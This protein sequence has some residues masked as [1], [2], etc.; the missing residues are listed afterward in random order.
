MATAH[1]QQVGRWY[2]FA[3]LASMCGG[4]L[5]SYVPRSAPVT[6]PDRGG[7]SSRHAR[8]AW[9]C[10]PLP[11]HSATHGNGL[12]LW[13]RTRGLVLVV[14]TMERC[15]QGREAGQIVLAAFAPGAARR[16]SSG[17]LPMRSLMP[18]HSVRSPSPARAW[19]ARLGI[20]RASPLGCEFTPLS[21]LRNLVVH[22]FE[23]H[24]VS[25]LGVFLEAVA[26]SRLNGHHRTGGIHNP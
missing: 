8:Y 16:S 1:D 10:V 23:R 26:F 3:D 15:L 7:F 11:R 6:Y 5:P 4:V 18:H 25:Q 13:Q 9:A 21:G 22:H 12:G 14:S 20:E 24:P 2:A 19:R 17:S